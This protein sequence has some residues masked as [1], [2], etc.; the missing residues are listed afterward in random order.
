M[1][2]ALVEQ[3]TISSRES[4][5]FSMASTIRRIAVSYTHLVLRKQ[6]HTKICHGKY[7]ECQLQINLLLMGT[8]V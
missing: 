1:E 5:P 6:Q 7:D 3:V 2:E 4:V 8:C